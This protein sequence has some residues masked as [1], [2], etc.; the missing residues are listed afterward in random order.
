LTHIPIENDGG[1]GS[2]GAHF[3][4]TF[5]INEVMTASVIKNQAFSG[6]GFNLLKD[7]GWY[8]IDDHYFE[9]FTVGKD[10]GCE[11]MKACKDPNNDHYFCKNINSQNSGCIIDYTGIGPCDT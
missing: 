10:M 11:W 9:T 4:R 2:V 5:F 8:G 3:E 1:D 7:S 6:F